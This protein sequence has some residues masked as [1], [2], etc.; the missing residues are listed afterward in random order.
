MGEKIYY[1]KIIFECTWFR[2][3]WN[4][5][6]DVASKEGAFERL[7]WIGGKEKVV[8]NVSVKLTDED[9]IELLPSINALDFEPYR[10]VDDSEEWLC[11]D[12]PV[13][14]FIGITD[15]Y[16]PLYQHYIYF[17]EGRKEKRPYEKLY[18]Y[19]EEKY[20]KKMG[21]LV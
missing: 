7:K 20:F 18:R 17:N 12:A 15:S 5:L 8:E 6:L 2:D 21:L 16:L 1:T 14:K 19:L 13:L 10:Y 11:Y 3:D 4:I 9:I